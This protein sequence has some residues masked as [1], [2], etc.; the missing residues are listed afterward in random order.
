MPPCAAA[1]RHPEQ[2]VD[3]EPGLLGREEAVQLE[4]DEA[5][6][7][8]VKRRARRQDLLSKLTE[9]TFVLDHRRDRRDL[10]AR[11]PRMLHGRPPFGEQR[12]SGHLTNAAPVIPAAAWPGSVQMNVWVPGVSNVSLIVRV[13]PGSRIA[14]TPWSP[15]MWSEGKF[16][17]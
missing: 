7:E 16:R 3:L 4:L 12:D 6:E 11:P 10:A 2:G 15:G 9:W 13:S 1:E 8:R 5:N 17:S 14:S